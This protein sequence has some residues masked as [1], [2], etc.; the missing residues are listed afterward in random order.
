MVGGIG[1]SPGRQRDVHEAGENDRRD[2]ELAPEREAHHRLHRVFPQIV[3]VIG[4]KAHREGNQAAKPRARRE[5][6]HSVV[7]AV[8]EAF[9][10]RLHRRVAD[11][12]EAREQRPRSEGRRPPS[13]ARTEQND[14]HKRRRQNKMRRPRMTESVSLSTV[15]ITLT[16]RAALQSPAIAAASS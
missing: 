14:S 15:P 13:H 5:K 12:A 6:M 4:V 8:Q 9:G 10:A 2:D 11:E 16:S 1:G 7:Q 3:A